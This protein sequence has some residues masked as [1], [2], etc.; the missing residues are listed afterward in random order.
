MDFF[1]LSS[2]CSGEGNEISHRFSIPSCEITQQTFLCQERFFVQFSEAIVLGISTKSKN[3]SLYYSF[4][5]TKKLVLYSDF[6][7]T[8]DSVF[9]DGEVDDEAVGPCEPNKVGEKVAV[10]RATGVWESLR[11]GCILEPI[12]ELLQQ[13]QVT[14]LHHFRLAST[15]FPYDH[16]QH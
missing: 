16:F 2:V 6:L 8:D 15:V 4:F 10:C 13:S 11:D 9:G 5:P 14:N 7:C 12:H 3:D 1:V